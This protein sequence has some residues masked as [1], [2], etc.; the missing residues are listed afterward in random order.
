MTT[1]REPIKIDPP[2]P[3]CTCDWIL[4]DTGQVARPWRVSD[5]PDCPY[6]HGKSKT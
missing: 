4:Q 6:H 3:N 2:I 5:D 1:D